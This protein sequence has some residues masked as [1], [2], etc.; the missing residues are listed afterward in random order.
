VPSKEADFMAE[1]SKPTSPERQKA[2]QGVA[3]SC[4]IEF[5]GPEDN[6]SDAIPR[7]H[8]IS[9]PK[10]PN[11]SILESECSV[12]DSPVEPESAAADLLASR[13]RSRSQPALHSVLSIADHFFA[14][15]TQNFQA[16]LFQQGSTVLRVRFGRA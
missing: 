12:Y 3:M 5:P 15:G 6:N 13:S 11:L 1:I 16:L 8:S 14:Q 4:G 10:V 2:L 7:G 9:I